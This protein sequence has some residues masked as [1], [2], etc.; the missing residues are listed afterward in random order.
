MLS[1]WTLVLCDRADVRNYPKV[2]K[3]IHRCIGS[4]SESLVRIDW[5]KA[6]EYIMVCDSSVLITKFPET[7]LIDAT[8]ARKYPMMYHREY[9]IEVISKLKPDEDNLHHIYRNYLEVRGYQTSNLYSNIVSGFAFELDQGCPFI[10]GPKLVNYDLPRIICIANFKMNHENMN[11]FFNQTYPNKELWIP[12]GSD[13]VEKSN[14]KYYNTLDDI[15]KNS[16]IAEWDMD[17]YNALRLHIQY[18]ETIKSDLDGTYFMKFFIANGTDV[19]VRRDLVHSIMY[20]GDGKKY[21]SI[22]QNMSIKISNIELGMEKAS[23]DD[24][25]KICG[26]LGRTFMLND[27]VLESKFDM[28]LVWKM[29]GDLNAWW[30]L[31]FIFVFLIIFLILAFACFNRFFRN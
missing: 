22:D 21:R 26:I 7:P 9:L 4:T 18:T 20:N 13:I 16:W 28:N 25:E 17:W 5:R 1:K 23:E 3:I 29:S 15:P 19:A 10:I 30:F 8:C 14:V 12:T 11:S 2:G 31:L 24:H 6:T 27:E